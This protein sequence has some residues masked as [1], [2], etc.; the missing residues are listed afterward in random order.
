[1]PRRRAMQSAKDHVACCPEN[2]RP[3][4]QEEPEVHLLAPFNLT[5][6]VPGMYVPCR[7]GA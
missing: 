5:R 4:E 3:N 2:Q 6:A 1:M 7:A